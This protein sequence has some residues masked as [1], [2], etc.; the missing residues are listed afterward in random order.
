MTEIGARRLKYTRKSSYW[1]IGWVAVVDGEEIAGMKFHT[2][3]EAIAYAQRVADYQN[4]NK[5]EGLEK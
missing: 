1:R 4:D 3:A 2:R 5:T